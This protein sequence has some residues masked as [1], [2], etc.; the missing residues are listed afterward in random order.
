MGKNIKPR[1]SLDGDEQ[2]RFE[3]EI[4]KGNYEKA[5]SIS[6]RPRDDKGHSETLSFRVHPLYPRMASELQSKE[7]AF[8]TLS[9]LFRTALRLGIGL[10]LKEMKAGA[11]IGDEVDDTLVAL[12]RLEKVA[13]A[14]EAYRKLE[15]LIKVLPQSLKVYKRDPVVFRQ[16]L[17]E[18]ESQIE[19]LR[20]PFWKSL[21]MKK[22][23]ER[24]NS[25]EMYPGVDQGNQYDLDEEGDL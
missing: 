19:K 5:I 24:V 13:K 4:E 3:A 1:F 6:R 21:L 14:D 2:E 23:R 22:V 12:D 16:K 25:M 9:D 15:E 10:I 18:F 7:P 8:K 17:H 20:D 11:K